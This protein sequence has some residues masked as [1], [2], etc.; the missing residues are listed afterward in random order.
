M[1]VLRARAGEDQLSLYKMDL[2]DFNLIDRLA[3]NLNGTPID[4]LLPNEAITGTKNT[5]FGEPDYAVCGGPHACQCDGADE[6]CQYLGRTCRRQRAQND[7]LYLQSDWV[8]PELWLSQLSGGQLCA[9]PSRANNCAR[10]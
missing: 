1:S 7:V 3:Q 9:Q 2:M 10:S 5:A 8:Q 4:A 6:T